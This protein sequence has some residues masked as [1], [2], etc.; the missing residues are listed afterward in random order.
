MNYK[1]LEKICSLCGSSGDEK[2]V[3]EYIISEI[4]DYADYCQALVWH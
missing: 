1:K 2:A 3:S 4:K